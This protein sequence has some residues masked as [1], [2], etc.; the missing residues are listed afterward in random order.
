M[1][2]STRIRINTS[3]IGFE[4]ALPVGKVDL[5]KKVQ[6]ISDCLGLIYGK[7]VCMIQQS[8]IFHCSADLGGYRFGWFI[9]CVLLHNKCL[10]CSLSA[11]PTPE[12]FCFIIMSC[13]KWKSYW[14]TYLVNSKTHEVIYLWIIVFDELNSSD[15]TLI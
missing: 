14:K 1:Y 11:K 2:H 8:T 5:V 10:Y 15:A 9:H 13:L 12:V 6:L 7:C 3:V 4:R